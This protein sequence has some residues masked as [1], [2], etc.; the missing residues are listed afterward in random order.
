MSQVADL[1][2]LGCIFF[3]AALITS[4]LIEEDRK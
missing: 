2:A 3:V 1:V 4:R